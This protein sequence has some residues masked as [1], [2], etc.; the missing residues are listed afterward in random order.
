[1]TEVV[2]RGSGE[3]E[4]VADQAELRVTYSANGPDRS[5]AVETL[6]ERVVGVDAVL[7]SDAMADAVEVRQRSMHVGDRWDR[8][9]RVGATAQLQLMLRVTGLAVLDDLL[10]ALFSAEPEWLDGPHWSL[11]DETAAVREAQRLA[12]ADARARAEA[13]A[14]ALGGQLGTLLRLSDD[15]AERPYPVVRGGPMTFAAEAAAVSRDSVRQLGLVP[16]HV[17]VRA[18]CTASWSLLT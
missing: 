8:N 12:V 17:T 6:G 4:V 10:A 13:Y 5:R 15:G 18:A 11:T 2:T 3:H 9:R 1:M 7:R 16:E 14:E